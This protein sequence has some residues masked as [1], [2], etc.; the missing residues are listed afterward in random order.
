MEQ[1]EWAEREVGVCAKNQRHKNKNASKRLP[2]PMIR[3]SGYQRKSESTF[4]ALYTFV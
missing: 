1:E 2:L 3:V 4:F